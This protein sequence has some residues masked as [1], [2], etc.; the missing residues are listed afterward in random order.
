MT[1]QLSMFDAPAVPPPA[2][3]PK[4]VAYGGGLDSWAMLL[5][6]IRRG[7]LPDVVAFVDVADPMRED[8]GEWPQTY[9]HLRHVVK[10]LCER[11]G[12]EFVI[13]DSERYPVRDARSLF[14]WLWARHQIPVAGDDR[15]CTVV[16]KVERFERWLGDRF[17]DQDVEV[18]VGFEAGEERRM[19]RDPNAGSGRAKPSK[20]RR[21]KNGEPQRP[22]ARR[23][24]RFPLI[25]QRLCRCRCLALAQGWGLPVPPGSACI[26]CPYGKKGDWQLLARTLP[27][28]FQRV[29][30]LEARKPPTAAG[31][32][33]SIMDFRKRWKQLP[34]GT[35]VLRDYK[36]PPLP[37]YIRGTYK[38]QT[39]GCRVCGAAVKVRKVMGCG[40]AVEPAPRGD[41]DLVQ[42]AMP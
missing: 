24:N 35:R 16:A 9:A 25:E 23:H 2:K 3:R 20:R 39:K 28:S 15:I 11:Q 33:L 17:P 30:E 13:I 38:P 37:D 19:E 32:K 29:V 8:P 18:W 14:S 7:E 4:V 1:A 22:K 34:D 10:P 41:L 27:D 40:D 21:R 5:D 36:A 12:I 6:A 26:F 42:A 31:F